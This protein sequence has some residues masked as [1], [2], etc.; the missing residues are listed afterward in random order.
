M[1]KMSKYGI[2]SELSFCP[3]NITLCS[4]LG[5]SIIL[6]NQDTD[7]TSPRVIFYNKALTYYYKENELPFAE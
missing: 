4:D 3:S 1:Q 5:D 2:L 7:N 6:N